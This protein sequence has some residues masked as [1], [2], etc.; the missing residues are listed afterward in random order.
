[1]DVDKIMATP[2]TPEQVAAVWN[3]YHATKGDGT[4]RGYL[5]ASVPASTFLSLVRTAKQFP[6]FIIPLERTSSDDQ[7]TGHEFY[8][9]EWTFHRTNYDNDQAIVM[10]T[11]LQEYKLRQEFAQPY[12]VMTLYPELI[13]THQIGLLRGEISSSPIRSGEF[14]LSQNDAQLLG[15]GLQKFY[16]AKEGQAG[17][18]LLESFHQNKAEFQWEDLLRV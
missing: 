3:A 11:P 17:R 9:L 1:M 16:L 8:Y 15:V 18:K 6:K 2:H 7:S 12:L 13:K 10:F 4:G 14:L 5:S